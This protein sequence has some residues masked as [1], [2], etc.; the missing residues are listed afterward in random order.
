[1]GHNT[2]G[3]NH[4][5]PCL[6]H[7]TLSL[8]HTSHTQRY[9]GMTFMLYH[10]STRFFSRTHRQTRSYISTL[11]IRQVSNSHL[12]TLPLDQDQHP[13]FMHSSMITLVSNKDTHGKGVKHHVDYPF[14]NRMLSEDRFG[15]QQHKTN[16]FI[17]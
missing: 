8:H 5:S 11:S 12:L 17:T 13:S 6:H 14:F 4:G 10:L 15:S 16:T 3:I 1:M 9:V 2:I 7:L